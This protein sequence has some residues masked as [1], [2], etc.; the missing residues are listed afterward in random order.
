VYL[1]AV[2]SRRTPLALLAA[3]GLVVAACGSDDDSSPSA[4][5]A[6]TGPEVTSTVSTEAPT[7]SVDSTD[8]PAT[9]GAVDQAAIDAAA[10]N[11]LEGQSAQGVTAFYV[12]ISDPEAGEFVS[13][14]GDASSGGPAATIDDNFRIGSVSKTATATVVLQLVDSGDIS[15]DDT[16][17]DLAPDLAAAHPEIE[18]LTVE[19]L[20]NMTSGVSDYLNDVD[21]VAP[22]VVADPTK[23]WTADELVGAGIEAG[24]AEPGTAGYSST[25]YVILQVIAETVTGSSLQDL[26]AEK[27]SGPLGLESFSLPPNE[28]TTLSDP[29][30]HGYVNGACVDELA[31][32]G[33][34]L[35]PGT[36][37]TDWNV[38]FTQ[39]AGGMNS[40]IGDLLG[41]AKSGSGSSLLSDAMAEQRVSNLQTLP[42]GIDYGLGIIDLIGWLGHPGEA[43][44][45]EA[46]AIQNPDTGAAI[47]V[48]GNGCGGLFAGF[49]EFIGALY[50]DQFG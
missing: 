28:D 16:V 41:W 24:V 3:A 13:A 50:P 48:A 46:M 25:N 10:A 18:A 4:T 42:E 1:S 6:T 7:D 47:A 29:V 17:G 27:V 26:I 43:I 33:A 30:A 8:A 9:T 12:G 49:L 2:I 14:Y 38:S 32:D 11:F 36:D 31:A 34:T 21:V 5:T 37:T 15:L 35:E 19:Q 39:G 22:D 23:V 44:G 40:T 45:W 20:L